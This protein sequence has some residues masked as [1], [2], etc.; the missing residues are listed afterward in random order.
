MDM[1]AGLMGEIKRHPYTT[2]TA[3]LCF[4]AM[5]VVW[6]MSARAGDMQ[7]LE[8]KI[9]AVETTVRRESAASELNSVRRELFDVDLRIRTLEREGINVDILLYKR[10]DDLQLQQR[11]LEARLRDID[12][13]RQ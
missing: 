11:L 7:K 10:R 8:D 1:T 5:P 9:V 12:R 3:M 6:T 13:A 4:A 2:V